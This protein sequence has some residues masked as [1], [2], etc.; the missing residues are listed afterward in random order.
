M[1]SKLFAPAYF[2]NCGLL[3]ILMILLKYC[4]DSSNVSEEV[5]AVIRRSTTIHASIISLN[6][7]RLRSLQLPRS[8]RK[9]FYGAKLSY[10]PNNDSRFQLIRIANSGDVSTYPGPTKCQN[11]TIC[12]YCSNIAINHRAV[13]CK[14]CHLR[15]HIKCADIHPKVYKTIS[16]MCSRC[17]Q[18]CLPL[19]LSTISESYLTS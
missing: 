5:S 1:A 8:R 12:P 16:W 15:Y 4:N 11:E 13:E 6:H 2:K 14:Q 7:N 3:I 9:R 19:N 17:L 10:Y 18:E